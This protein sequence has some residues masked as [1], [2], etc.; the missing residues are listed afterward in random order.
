MPLGDLIAVAV[1]LPLG[2]YY[3]HKKILLLKLPW[4]QTF[5]APTIAAIIIVGFGW[6]LFVF[7]YIPLKSLVGVFLAIL[8]LAG[9]VLLVIPYFIWVPLTVFLGAWDDAGRNSFRDAS[10]I[11]GFAGFLL[12]PMYRGLNWAS[13]RSSMFN[14]FKFD[15]SLALKEAKELMVQSQSKMI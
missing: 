8:P 3:V 14:R 5:I 12:K 13:Q 11:S 10:K 9:I 15:D 7:I 1:T 2:Y 4:I 6:L